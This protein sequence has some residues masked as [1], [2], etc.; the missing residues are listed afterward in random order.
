MGVA[1]TAAIISTTNAAVANAAAHAARVDRCK[2]V[3][4][5]FDARGASVSQMQEYAYCVDTVYPKEMTGVEVFWAKA[6]FVIAIVGLVLGAWH[7]YEDD[8]PMYAVITGLAGFLLVP[9]AALFIYGLGCGII[10][11]FS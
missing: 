6:L 3:I 2:T 11:L 4:E 8:G 10:W 7:G 1:A 9:T 5:N